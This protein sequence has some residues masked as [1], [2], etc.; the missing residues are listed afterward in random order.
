MIQ[1]GLE[2]IGLLLKNVQFPWKAIHVAGTNGKGSICH[3]AATLLARRKVRVGK[4]TSP[5]LIDR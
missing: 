4:F 1:P 3:H 5:H 2:R